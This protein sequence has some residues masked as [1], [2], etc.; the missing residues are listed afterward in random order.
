MQQKYGKN[1]NET[2]HVAIT[3]YSAKADEEQALK[4][5]GS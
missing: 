4:A 5:L 2:P 1:R 3:N